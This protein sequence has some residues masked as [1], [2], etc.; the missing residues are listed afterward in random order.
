MESFEQ[1]ALDNYGSLI[2]NKSFARKAGFGSRAIPVY[3]REWIVAHYVGDSPDLMD[4]ARTSIADFVRKYVPNKGDRE[5]IKNQLY[6]QNDVKLLDD[7]AVQVNLA[8]GDRYLLIPFLD[9][10]KASV[11]PMIV[12]DNEMLLSSGIWGVGTLTYAP[13]TDDGPGQVIMRS[14][15]PFQLASLDIGYFISRRQDFETGEW[16]NF[17]I[18]SMGFN[19]HIYSERQKILLISRLLP[20]VEPR[21]NLIELAP[22]GTGKSFVFENMSRYVTVRSGAITAPVLFYNDARK[23]PGL[24][25]RFDCVVI[26]EAQKVRG[27]RSGELTALL[28]SYLEAGRFGRG[29]AGSITAESGIVILANIDLDERKRPLHEVIGLFRDF[30]NFL[31]ETAFLDRFSGLLPGWDLPRVSKDTPAVCLGLKGDIFGE[32]LHMLRNDISYRDFVKTNMELENS[33]D[34]RDSRAIEAG[35]TGFL[36]ILFPHQEPS[37]EDFYQY[38]VN[39]ALE[40]RQ[41]VRDELCKL[42][43]EYL[44]ISMRS[45]FPDDYQLGH[46]KAQFIDPD[47]IDLA[48]LP[49]KAIEPDVVDEKILVT[50]QLESVDEP[51]NEP[52]ERTLLIPDGETGHSYKSLF[53][54]Y[55]KGARHI[56]LTDPYIRMEYQVRNLLAFIG[57][58]D[59]VDGP[60]DLHLTSSADDEYQKRINSQKFDEIASSIQEHGI[61]FTYEYSDT[62][63][64]RGIELDN[65]WRISIDRGL[66]IFQKPDSK[67]E[68]S[69][70]DQAKKR[71][72]ETEMIYLKTMDEDG[73]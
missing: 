2:I 61:N 59:T 46:K 5:A 39:P 17:I 1:K 11:P 28:K 55:L 29:S 30:P 33:D 12:R 13:P 14:F 65:G 67:Y 73:A 43:R 3:V 70:V 25:T 47:N 35:A 26:D 21:F 27:D 71:C 45:K 72:R 57:I 63:H 22:K 51:E 53:G 19:H 68:L 60:V 69:E 10:S 64:R 38:C 49:K 7:Y 23:T 44:P 48:K 31:R 58:I 15:T 66:D 9:E 32:I 6:E 20:M 36:K 34:M 40:M 4:D 16:I 18:N 24:I 42:D 54:P 50:S 8:K 37:E 41:R 52:E 56:Y 62:V